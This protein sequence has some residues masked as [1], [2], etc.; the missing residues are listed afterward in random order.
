MEAGKDHVL[1]GERSL[2]AEST[3]SANTLRW[4]CAWQV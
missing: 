1:L 4:D 3:S 2:Q